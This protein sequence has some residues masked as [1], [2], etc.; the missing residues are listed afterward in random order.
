M[1]SRAKPHYS[2]QVVFTTPFPLEYKGEVYGSYCTY[3]KRFTWKYLKCL[4]FGHSRITYTDISVGATVKK[5]VPAPCC[6]RTY[7]KTEQLNN[8]ATGEEEV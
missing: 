1:R 4:V 2:R 8:T 5:C 7:Y 3:G 6:G